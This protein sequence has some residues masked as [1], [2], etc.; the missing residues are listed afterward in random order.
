M[1]GVERVV[2]YAPAESEPELGLVVAVG[3]ERAAAYAAVDRQ[4]AESFTVSGVTLIAALLA[5]WQLAVHFIQRP[6]A[7]LASAAERWRR[8]DLTARAGPYDRSEIGRLGQAFDAMADAVTAR[9]RHL[10]DM[11]ES[12][13]DSV[14]AFDRDLRFT[15]LNSR[16]VTLIAQGRD[17]VGQKFRDAFPAA[18]GGPFW[19]AY[20]R[21]LAERIP[22]QVDAFSAP[23]GAHLEVNVCPAE[24]GGITVFCRDVTTQHRAQEELRHLAHHDV[25]TGLG[26]RTRFLD[27]MK[28][29]A[30]SGVSTALVLLDLDGFKHINDTLGHRA[31][32]EVLR[33]VAARL[34]NRLGVR[35][36]LA[37]LG[38]DEFAFLLPGVHS[39]T[40]V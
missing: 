39:A 37:R 4:A 3:L 16:A 32:D 1:D 26:N 23:L 35:G 28:S 34:A 18:V 27:T 30:A 6:L 13:T 10:R 19:E 20:Q 9:N 15:F 2:G 21:G 14:F 38:G 7:R 40:Q 22:T 5:A 25:L 24:D 12:T 31:G 33:D 29:T 8:G 36:T 11:L 17:L